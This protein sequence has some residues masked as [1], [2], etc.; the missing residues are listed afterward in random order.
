MIWYMTLRDRLRP[1]S[2]F[3]TANLTRADAMQLY[4]A[5]SVKENAVRDGLAAVGIDAQ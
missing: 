2:D 1:D 3:Q 4:G 5:G